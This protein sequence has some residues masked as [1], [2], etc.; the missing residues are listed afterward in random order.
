MSD[1]V[2]KKFYHAARNG[3]V[4]EVSALLRDHPEIRVN[5]T[6]QHNWTPL[7]MASY[8]AHIEVVKLLLA[9]PN[10]SVNLKDSYG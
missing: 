5:W 4:T 8:F 9:H 10:I 6:T 3:L 2:E 1:A 7:Y